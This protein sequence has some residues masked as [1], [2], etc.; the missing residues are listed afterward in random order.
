[1]VAVTQ[2][3]MINFRRMTPYQGIVKS[4]A[5]ALLLVAA[6]A[7]QAQSLSRAQA[8]AI[9]LEANPQVRQSLEQINILEGRI[10]EARADALPGVSWTTRVARSRDPGLLNSPNFDRFPLEFRDALSPLPANLFDTMTDFRQT[11]FSFKLGK[12]LEAARLARTAGQEELRRARQGTALDAIRSYNQLLFAIE[13]LRVAESSVDQKQ[14][15]LDFARNRKS[16]GVATELEVLRAEVD[17][18][19][20]RAELLRAQTHVTAARATLNTVMLRP[21]NALVEPTDTLA[22]VP[23]TVTFDDAVREA[24]AARPELRTLRFTQQVRDKLVDVTAAEAKPR[25]DFDGGYGFS[26]RQPENLFHF[27]FR[28]WIAAVTVTVPVFDGY[29]T[30]AKVAVARAERDVV[31]QQIAVI[32]NQIRLD[33]QSAWDTLL[34][35]ERTLRVAGLNVSQARRAAEMTEANYRLGAATPLDVVD[36]QQALNQAENVRNQALYAHANARATLRYVMGQDPLDD[37]PAA[38][39]NVAGE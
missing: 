1:M 7:L 25:V 30:A 13:E 21:T 27:D 33:V 28:R 4:A 29:R 23:I 36:V 37:R 14:R 11:L 22:I 3:S 16:A 34:L 5:V 32:E 8:V 26:V 10:K 24:L 35:A 31:T 19:N 20:Q 15:H 12:A 2:M 38:A 39:G 6:P 17:L 18:E 9:A